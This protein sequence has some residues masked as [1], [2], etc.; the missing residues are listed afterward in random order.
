MLT[1]CW[2]TTV[3]STP[4]R[5]CPTPRRPPSVARALDPHLAEPYAS[6]AL[7]R[8]L[9]RLGMGGGRELYLRAIALN[10]GYA[11]AHHWLSVDHYCVIG[12]FDEAL[13]EIE[14]A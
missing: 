7:I 12:H 13:A 14:I 2:S 10:P 9:L 3:C 4:P 11:T 6:L 1:A 8:G 5:A